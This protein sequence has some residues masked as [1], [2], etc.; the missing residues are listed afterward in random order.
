[1]APIKTNNPYASYFD[2]FS[3]TGTDAV[4]PASVS[5][6][7]LTATGGIISDY[8]DG[9]IYYRAHIFTNSGTFDV[10]QLGAAPADL[11]YLVVAGGGGGGCHSAGGGGGGGYR[12]SVGSEKVQ[13]AVV[14][15]N[16]LSQQLFKL[17]Q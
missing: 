15:Q 4:N 6:P 7:G 13:V 3:K 11:E 9:G 14:R 1:M 10:T 5:A 2:F 12:S 16:Q 17:I 8:E